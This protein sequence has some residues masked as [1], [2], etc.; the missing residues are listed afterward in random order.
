MKASQTPPFTSHPVS[1]R[2]GQLFISTLV[3]QDV[4]RVTTDEFG[5]TL[6]ESLFSEF[7]ARIRAIVEDDQGALYL[8]TDSDNGS[9][10]KIE[11]SDS[12]VS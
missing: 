4:K 12:P 1:A 8:L 6:E 7:E 2:Q 5:A 3:D 10:I 11:R 9:I